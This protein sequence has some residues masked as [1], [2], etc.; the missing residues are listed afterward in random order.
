VVFFRESEKKNRIEK[1]V[2][3]VCGSVDHSG[4]MVHGSTLDRRA[5]RRRSSPEMRE[6]PAPGEGA[7]RGSP[8][9][10]R[11]GSGNAH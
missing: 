3:K 9:R 6:G 2:S 8:R 7:R 5:V 10:E 1:C 11:E 4:E